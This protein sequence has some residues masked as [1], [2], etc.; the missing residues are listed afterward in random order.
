MTDKEIVS[1]LEKYSNAVKGMNSVSLAKTQALNSFSIYITLGEI[2][3]SLKEMNDL[4]KERVNK[5]KNSYEQMFNG[6]IK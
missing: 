5:E 6:I 2:V 3:A 4:T 1:A